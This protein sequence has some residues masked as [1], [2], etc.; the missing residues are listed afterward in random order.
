MSMVVNGL[1]KVDREDILAKGNE[2]IRGNEYKLKGTK[3]GNNVKKF[4]YEYISIGV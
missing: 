1:E 2:R 3:C 4:K